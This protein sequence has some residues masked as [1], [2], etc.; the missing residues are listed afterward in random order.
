MFS[1][2][3]VFLRVLFRVIVD[4]ETLSIS[5]GCYGSMERDRL[6]E[7]LSRCVW[8]KSKRGAPHEYIL[9]SAYPEVFAL[10]QPL[11][12][13][14]SKM[15][16]HNGFRQKYWTFEGYHYWILPGLKWLPKCLVL[17]R[18]PDVSAEDSQADL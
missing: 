2:L 12:K 13:R 15:G 16:M 10:V 7:L 17:N 6:A 5:L 18:I 1:F 14:E 9:D 11:V 8:K 3:H 4:G